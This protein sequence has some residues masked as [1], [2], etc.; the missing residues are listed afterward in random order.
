MC[1]RDSGITKQAVSR[2]ELGQRKA[3][4]DILFE[5]SKIFRCSIND[6][7]PNSDMNLY[8]ETIAAH[9]DPDATEEEIE[10]ILAYIEMK[11]NLRKNKKK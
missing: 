4:Q 11:R 7:F 2:Y 5:L 3:N 10:E 9:I 6:F 8:S 1:I